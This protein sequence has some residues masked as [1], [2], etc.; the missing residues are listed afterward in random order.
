MSNLF[1]GKL[2]MTSKIARV[3]KN[4]S[5]NLLLNRELF[6]F[7][8]KKYPNTKQR[9]HSLLVKFH[10]LNIPGLWLKKK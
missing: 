7:T 2:K 3:H 8:W 4:F 5:M 1:Q 9:I 10:I 6:S